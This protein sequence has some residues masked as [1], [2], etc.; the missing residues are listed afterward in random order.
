MSVV[1]QSAADAGIDSTHSRDSA[2]KNNPTTSDSTRVA[3]A[4]EPHEGC[5]PSRDKSAHAELG[6]SEIKASKRLRSGETKPSDAS[7]RRV[8]RQK[9]PTS[10]S[11]LPSNDQEFDNTTLRYTAHA[12]E[13]LR[14]QLL[15]QEAMLT[16]A[17]KLSS[18][19]EG[20]KMV[21]T[22]ME[23]IDATKAAIAR[24]VN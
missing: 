23:R 20:K 15:E 14:A 19:Q 8:K 3:P 16:K 10:G 18:G 2:S 13:K 7:G 17:E 6:N 24:A 4:R 22:I 1:T 21:R 12:V 5:I 9:S 11:Q